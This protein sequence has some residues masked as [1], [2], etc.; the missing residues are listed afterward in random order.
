MA[1]LQD[2][3]SEGHR[4]RRGNGVARG[5]TQIATV[6]ETDLALSLSCSVFKQN[7]GSFLTSSYFLLRLCPRKA[8]FISKQKTTI[9]SPFPSTML[10]N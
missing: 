5:S 8:H 6:A 10:I 4:A 2:L 3:R 7:K 1:N 9:K